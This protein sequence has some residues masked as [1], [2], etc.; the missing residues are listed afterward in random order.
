MSVLMEVAAVVVT[1]GMT[2]VVNVEAPPVVRPWVL[3]AF[4][5]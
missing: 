1:V 3:V 5:R 2:G 4:H